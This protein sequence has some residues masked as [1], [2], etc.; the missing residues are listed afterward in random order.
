[1]T[2]E[3]L[4]LLDRALPRGWDN[5]T[6]VSALSRCLGWSERAVREGLE[7]LVNLW[8]VP[9]V[10]LPTNPGVFIATRPEDAFLAQI[11]VDR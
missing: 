6:S 3:E 2:P 8:R 1:M 4:S 11:G 5:A 7:E 10:T 9:V